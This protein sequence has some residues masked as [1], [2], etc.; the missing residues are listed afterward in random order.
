LATTVTDR[1]GES[2]QALLPRGRV[3]VATTANVTLGTAL[4]EGDTI[5]G[6]TLVYGDLVLVKSQTTQADNGVYRVGDSGSRAPNFQTFNDIAGQLFYVMEGTTYGDTTWLSTANYGGTLGTTALPFNQF[7]GGSALG[8]LANDTGRFI[9]GTG[10]GF[11]SIT[12]AAVLTLIG[13]MPTDAT[14]V[15]IA[16]LTSRASRVYTTD[17]GGHT[18]LASPGVGLVLTDSGIA[19]DVGRISEWVPAGSMRSEVVDGPTWGLNEMTTN[20]NLLASWDFDDTGQQFAQFDWAMPTWWDRGTLSYKYYWSHATDT[21]AAAGASGV[22]FRLQAVAVQ[23]DGTADVAFGTAIT[24]TDAGGTAND[25][26]ESAESNAMTVAGTLT[27]GPYT[28]FRVSRDATNAS[29]TMTA[30]ARLHGVKVFATR[31]SLKDT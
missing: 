1:F 18:T 7:D 8:A 14:L 11:Q 30:N 31:N 21:G 22:A 12:P 25:I 4:D 24:V 28:M 23:N 13:A 3:R 10:T 19:V 29:D 16:A 9:V 5:D 27:G 17:T 26:Y 2:P 20:K 6:V 15:E